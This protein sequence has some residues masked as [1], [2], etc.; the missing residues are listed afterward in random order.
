MESTGIEP[1][2]LTVALLLP[3]L[4]LSYDP[5][6]ALNRERLSREMKISLPLCEPILHPLLALRNLAR[7]YSLHASPERRIAHKLR[8]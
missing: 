5:N 7:Q 1:A 8:I 2:P 4:A 6:V 3:V